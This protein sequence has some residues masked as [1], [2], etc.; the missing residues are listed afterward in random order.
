MTIPRCEDFS[1]SDRWLQARAVS[2]ELHD[3]RPPLDASDP[4]L[5]PENKTIRYMNS[6]RNQLID[7]LIHPGPWKEILPCDEICYNLMQSCPASMNFLCPLKDDIGKSYGVYTKTSTTCNYPGKPG[8]FS[9]AAY[10]MVD[11]MLISA[12][13]GL[14]LLVQFAS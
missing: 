14:V 2:Q 3:G 8:D 5:S 11:K 13:L 12:S 6:S 1:A 9:N 7:D 4:A 10:T